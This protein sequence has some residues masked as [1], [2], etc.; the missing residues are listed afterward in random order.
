[1]NRIANSTSIITEEDAK[2]KALDAVNLLQSTNFTVTRSARSRVVK[3]SQVLTVASDMLRSVDENRIDTIAYVVNFEGNEGYAVVAAD[4]R[5]S[6]QVLA[7]AEEGNLELETDNPGLALF[8]EQ[9]EN[10]IAESIEKSELVRDSLAQEILDKLLIENPELASEVSARAFY[11]PFYLLKSYEYIVLTNTS[12]PESLGS[13]SPLTAVE[14]N[15]GNSSSDL[16]NKYTK[17]KG[18][19]GKAPYTG[20]VAVA[21]AQIMAYWKY[22]SSI[23]GYTMNWSDMTRYTHSIY[24]NYM[25]NYKWINSLSSA[26]TNVKDNVARLMEQM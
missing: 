18:C 15:Q 3:N 11:S 14:W 17:S 9:A 16:Y 26:P 1:M 6:A 8:L 2:I 23:N 24:R 12:R 25:F 21:T 22:P 20:C 13:I 5:V 10:Y 7:C 19:G 4:E